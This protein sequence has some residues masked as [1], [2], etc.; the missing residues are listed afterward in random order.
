MRKPVISIKLTARMYAALVNLG[1]R[2]VA[3]ITGNA[4]FATPTPTMT[5]LQT[6]ITDVENAIAKWGPKTN[7]GSHADLV[8]LRL[9]ARLLADM[10]K[11]LAQYV[12]NTA[13]AAAGLD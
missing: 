2:V 6:A 13:Q 4:S 1:N 9:K 3:S 11:S 10:L 12:Q 5:V 7:R 8:D